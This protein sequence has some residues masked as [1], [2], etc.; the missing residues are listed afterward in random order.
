MSRDLSASRLRA[1]KL[2]SEIRNKGYEMRL[3]ALDLLTFEQRRLRGQLIETFKIIRGHSTLDPNLIF[4][5][6]NN[7]TWGH[8][9]KLEA[10]MF[11]TNK[12]R[13][14]MTVKVCALWNSLPMEVVYSTLVKAFK[15]N[16]DEIIRTLRY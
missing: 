3:Q 8:E 1:T 5:F 14:L 7:P 9:F 6:S 11:R 4:S 2:I 16:L 10:P 12:F 13:D 15:R